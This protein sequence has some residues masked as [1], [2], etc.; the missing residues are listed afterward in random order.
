MSASVQTMVRF[1]LQPDDK[2]L[3]VYTVSQEEFDRYH[4]AV[5]EGVVFH[6][7]VTKVLNFSA[8]LAPAPTPALTQEVQQETPPAPDSKKQETS[9]TAPARK[10]DK[11]T[12]IRIDRYKEYMRKQTQYTHTM[13]DIIQSCEGKMIPSRLGGKR[14]REY[15]RCMEAAKEARKEIAVE[16]KISWTSPPGGGRGKEHRVK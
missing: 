7:E 13:R 10:F 2:R 12:R 5:A 16:D 9:T 14:N 6:M 11:T 8:N 4:D 1:E 3:H 15:D